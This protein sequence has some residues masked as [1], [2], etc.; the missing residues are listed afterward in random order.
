M[1]YCVNLTQSQN[2]QEFE[3]IFLSDFLRKLKLA[4]AYIFL[5]SLPGIILAVYYVFLYESEQY[6]E[7]SSSIVV[8][9][10]EDS[11]INITLVK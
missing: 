11:N 10:E 4:T 9:S 6:H 7:K 3:D 5:T 8:I 2:F 1:N